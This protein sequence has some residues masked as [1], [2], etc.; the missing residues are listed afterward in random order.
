MAHTTLAVI[1]GNRDFFPDRLVTE[2]RKDILSLFDELDI[3]PVMLEETDT[4]LGSVET[5]SHA[6]RCADL[7]RANRDRIDGV[8]VALP[9]FG[10]EKG[11]ADTL[12]LANL[13]VPVLI[14]A[15]PDDL[16]TVHPQTDSFKA[17]LRKFVGV[18]RVRKG[19][20]GLRVGAVGAR[21]GN[22][23]TMR[24]SEKLLEDA[25]ITIVTV[26]FSEIFG[27]ANRLAD[28]DPRVGAKLAQITA[29]ADAGAVPPPRLAS[30]HSR[31]SPAP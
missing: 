26:D 30:W 14:Q 18:C 31:A 15:Y 23:N 10:D 17:D 8:L 25:G 6:K 27:H 4:K 11:V 2:A 29:Y 16:H 3:E 19:L 21:P 12:R 24:Y 7:F 9:N 1:L 22:F 28:N 20:R 13:D 5:W